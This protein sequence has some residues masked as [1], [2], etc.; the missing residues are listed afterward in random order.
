M[1]TKLAVGMAT[2]GMVKTK[3]MFS[4]VQLIKEIPANLV[5]WEGCLIHQ[6]RENIAKAVMN[7]D[8]THLLFIDS[9]MVFEPDALKKLIARDRDIIGA[10]YNMKILPPTSTVK[11]HDEKGNDVS[12]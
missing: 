9:D 11:I 7:S 1:L 2:N 3:T 8:C 12:K 5:T 6:N 10:P 4:I